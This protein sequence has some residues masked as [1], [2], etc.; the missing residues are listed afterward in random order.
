VRLQRAAAVWALHR[1]STLIGSGGPAIVP[2]SG[3]QQVENIVDPSTYRSS[4]AAQAACAG[5]R[6]DG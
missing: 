2:C 6:L 1:A 5:I 3:P 4:P